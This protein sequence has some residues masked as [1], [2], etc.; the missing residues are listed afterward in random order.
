M[1]PTKCQNTIEPLQKQ[2]AHVKT[3]KEENYT[4]MKTA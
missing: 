4:S 1:R 2:L 3:G